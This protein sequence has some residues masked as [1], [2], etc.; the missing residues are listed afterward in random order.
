MGNTLQKKP[1]EYLEKGGGGSSFTCEICIEPMAA[2][3]KFKNRNLCTHPFCQDCIARYIQVKVQDDNT[4]KIE[5]PG[6]DWFERSYCPNTNCMAMVVNECERSGRVKKTQCPNCKQWFC[7]QCKLK[8]H[9]GY[10][11]EESRNLRDQNDIV[12]GQLVERMKWARCPACGHCVERKDGCS[13][14]MCRCNT[15]FCYECGRKISSGCSCQT[16]GFCQL[17]ILTIAMMV[18]FHVIVL[19]GMKISHLERMTPPDQS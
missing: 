14:V 19:A 6:L 3:K 7:F 9:A 8:W 13:V 17:T 4:A 10:R 2:S 18:I 16:I 5:C 12:F 1:N 15:R 11:C